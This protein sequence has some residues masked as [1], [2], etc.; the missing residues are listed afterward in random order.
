MINHYAHDADR[1]S[2]WLWKGQNGRLINYFG[3][4][5]L[6]L[7]WY[8][9]HNYIKTIEEEIHDLKKGTLLVTKYVQQLWS[10]TMLSDSTCG[11]EIIEELYFQRSAQL[12]LP[13]S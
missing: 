9:T 3:I 5:K 2:Y 4:S 8:A 10:E 7:F 6:F 13:H 12:I 1:E 11:E